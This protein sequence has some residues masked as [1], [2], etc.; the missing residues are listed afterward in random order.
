MNQQQAA[1]S[2]G[3]PGLERPSVLSEVTVTQLA[4]LERQYDE[5]DREAFDARA[6]SYGWT[7]D[8]AQAVW[9]WL[10]TGSALAGGRIDAIEG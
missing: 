8:Q 10:G 7:A 4:E 6:N 5:G 9:T 3:E 1:A 2:D